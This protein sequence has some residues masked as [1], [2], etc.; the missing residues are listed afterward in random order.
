VAELLA[1]VELPADLAARRPAALSGG[2][3]QRV[4]IARALA[5]E[6]DVVLLDEPTS[7]LDPLVGEEI[8]AL[9][10][11][12]QAAFGLAYLFIS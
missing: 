1:A 3:K 10:K 11:R 6:P 9:L 8:L 5:A 2:Q 4:A 12:L 7:A